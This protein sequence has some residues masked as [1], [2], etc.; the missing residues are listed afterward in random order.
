MR[1]PSSHLILSRHVTREF[2]LDF[3]VSFIFFF[4]IFFINQILLLVRQVLLRNVDLATILQLVLCAIPQFLQ[5]VVPFATLSASSMV[6]GDLGAANE[7][8]ALR[9]SGISLVHVHRVLVTWALVLSVL[10]FFISDYLMPLS[11][12]TYQDLLGDV[13]RELPTFEIEPNSTNSVGDVVMYNGDVEGDRIDDIVMFTLGDGMGMT[14][15]APSGRLELVDSASF[16][17]QLTLED[18]Q[19]LVT[20]SDV[21]DHLAAQASSGSMYLD[22]SDQVPSLTDT[23]PSNLSNR[24][25]WPLM[26]SRRELRDRDRASFHE[27]RQES[28]ITLASLYDGLSDTAGLAD[29]QFRIDTELSRLDSIGVKEPVQFYFQYYSAEF[30]KKFALSLGCLALTLVSLPLSLVRIRHGRLVGFGLSLLIAVA[31]WY[32][33]FFSQLVIFDVG[34][35]A[36]LL[37]Y[38]PDVAMCVIGL[39]LLLMRR[40]E[41]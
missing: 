20:S 9:S 5:Y 38:I 15:T 27:S 13:M 6:L 40:R 23:S 37:M 7:L 22:F 35:N 33:L 16:I 39:G 25:L 30:N 26:E 41:L 17:Y 2:L 18:S 34:F 3:L 29:R 36:G 14:V 21:S 28:L 10:T 31:Y 4:F 19:V 24:E 1:S 32:I 12:R 8:L 11:S